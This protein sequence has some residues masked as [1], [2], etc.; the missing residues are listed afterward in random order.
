MLLKVWVDLPKGP[1][2]AAQA[3]DATWAREPAHA[4]VPLVAP[5]DSAGAIRQ[6]GRLFDLGQVAVRGD[7]ELLR[8]VDLVDFQGVATLL[9]DAGVRGRERQAGLLLVSEGSEGR[10]VGHLG[11]PVVPLHL[12]ARGGRAD[13]V[14]ARQPAQLLKFVKL[15]RDT[16]G[17]VDHFY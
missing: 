16:Q 17:T 11:R 7:D 6:E 2:L 1:A 13:E 12:P 9:A 3:A 14:Q 15:D 4:N 10:E 5:A 8:L